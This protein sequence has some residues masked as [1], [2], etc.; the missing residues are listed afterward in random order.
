VALAFPREGSD[1]LVSYLDEHEDAAETRRLVMATGRTC[2]LMPGDIG[3]AAHCRA[4]VDRAVQAFDRI[5]VPVN[6]PM[7]GSKPGCTNAPALRHTR[8]Q[9][10]ARASAN[11]RLLDGPV[12]P[13]AGEN[14]HVAVLDP[15]T[16]AVAVELDLVQPSLAG[17]RPQP[18]GQSRGMKAGRERRS[19]VWSLLY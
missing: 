2:V 18:C 16:H 19:G 6:D 17:S 10:L 14:P 12:K 1:L 9:S 5:R 3:K 11:W 7:V 13:R 4:L 8:H 15:S